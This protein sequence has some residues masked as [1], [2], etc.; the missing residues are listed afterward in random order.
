MVEWKKVAVVSAAG[1]AGFGLVVLAAFW[2][3]SWG[4]VHAKSPRTWDSSPVKASYVNAQ[5]RENDRANAAVLLYYNLQNDSDTDYRL[6][7][8]PGL[9]IMRRLASDHSLSSEEPIRLSY[10]T[11]LPAHQ[12]ARI[13][14]ETSHPF[15]W[16]ADNDPARQD[17]L[18]EFINQRLAGVEEF[19]LF[20]E[21]THSQI[22]FP[23]GWLDLP[24]AASV[25]K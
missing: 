22:A 21:T 13:A 18:R 24:A 6:A 1:G 7:E 10:A 25:K 14:L 5:L 16:P 20:D 15:D 8:R 19:V 9:V 11:F 4:R 17:K 23:K 12:R 3:L 2:G